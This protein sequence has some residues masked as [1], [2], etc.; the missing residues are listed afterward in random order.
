MKKNK[1]PL[2]TALF[3]LAHFAQAQTAIQAQYA[4]FYEIGGNS[5]VRGVGV[6][7]RVRYEGSR[8]SWAANAT[9]NQGRLLPP[10]YGNVYAPVSVAVSGLMGSTHSLEVGLG[11]RPRVHGVG[12]TYEAKEYSDGYITHFYQ[13]ISLDI[14]PT[15]GYR[16]QPADGRFFGKIYIVPIAIGEKSNGKYGALNWFPL[17]EVQYS[18]IGL[19][20]GFN[21]NKITENDDEPERKSLQHSVLLDYGQG[22]TYDLRIN[23]P[24]NLSFSA[25]L[26]FG[27]RT[28]GAVYSPHYGLEDWNLRGTAILGKKTAA[29]EAGVQVS[30]G[31]LNYYEETDGTA[32]EQKR[33]A[34]FVGV[35]V[36]FRLQYPTS[37]IVARAYILPAFA[38]AVRS[39]PTMTACLG[40]GWSF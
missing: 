8:F 9:F 12:K 27:M 10:Q 22:L 1:L 21:L 33:N 40:L 13:N 20:L 3:Y 11:V 39:A 14:L 37:G 29:F 31:I 7:R 5:F 16:V 35:P 18:P 26:G 23:R 32:V 4:A 34:I 6:D 15:V 25:S 30:T 38:P 2:I 36:G 17:S 19:C 28:F 24:E